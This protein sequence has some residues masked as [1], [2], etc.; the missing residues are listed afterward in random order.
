MQD[1]KTLLKSYIPALRYAEK[2]FREYDMARET[3]I[4]SPKMDG[5]PRSGSIS[6]LEMQVAIIERMRKK[7]EKEREKVLKMLD[8]ILDMIDTLQDPEQKMV[9]KL[10]YVYGYS[11]AEVAVSAEMAE[12]TV[13]YVHGKALAELR[14]NCSKLQ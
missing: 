11:W 9:I 6:G 5:M 8:E 1:I 14:K 7:A 13:Y 10:H 4:R 12:R 2:C 3:T